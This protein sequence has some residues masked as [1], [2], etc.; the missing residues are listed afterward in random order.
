[1]K[2]NN[3]DGLVEA[4]FIIQSDNIKEKLFLYNTTSVLYQENQLGCNHPL[5]PIFIMN[6]LS[7]GAN[8]KKFQNYCAFLDRKNLNNKEEISKCKNIK[9]IPVA[10]YYEEE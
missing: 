4:S 7:V 10:L 6:H 8:S 1:M 3:F 5:I 9:A 2:K